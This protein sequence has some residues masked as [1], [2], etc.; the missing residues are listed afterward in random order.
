MNG[1]L[2]IK[3]FS[4]IIHGQGWST[5]LV[6]F[7]VVSFL[8]IHLLPPKGGFLKGDNRGVINLKNIHK[9]Q[10]KKSKHY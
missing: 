2:L 6:I 1:K 4:Y 10:R 5:P 7:L 3:W 9:K 8:S